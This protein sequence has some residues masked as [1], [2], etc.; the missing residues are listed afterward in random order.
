MKK[1]YKAGAL[2]M[3]EIYAFIS[4]KNPQGNS[5]IP[6]LFHPLNLH[7]KLTN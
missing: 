2:R 3:G 7:A 6:E 5:V 4:Y 1:N